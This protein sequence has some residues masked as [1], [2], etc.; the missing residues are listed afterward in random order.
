MTDVKLPT[1][2]ESEDVYLTPGQVE[3]LA[4]AMTEVAPRYRTLVWVGCYCGPRIGELAALRW[5]KST[6]SAG[7]WR[8]AVRSSR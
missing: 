2:V 8:S 6:W 4:D 3:D 7:R 5:E 1:I